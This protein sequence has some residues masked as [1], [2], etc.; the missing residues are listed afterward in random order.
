MYKTEESLLMLSHEFK[1]PIA[2]IKG[3][4]ENLETYYKQGNIDKLDVI[5]SLEAIKR[6]IARISHISTNLIDTMRPNKIMFDTTSFDLSER[7]KGICKASEEILR[8]KNVTI[9]YKSEPKSILFSASPEVTDK[10][11]LNLISNAVKYNN[12]EE[13]K[14]AVS[15]RSENSMLTMKVKDNGIGISEKDKK[16]IFDKFYRGDNSFTRMAEGSGLGL[17]LVK[18]M[19]DSL[20]G[21]IDIKS[22]KNGTTFIFTFPIVSDMGMAEYAPTSVNLERI[23]VALSDLL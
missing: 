3:N 6:N 9:T 18:K 1:T 13:I 20:N 5:Q 7:Y 17:Y 12:S 19:V 14:I 16:R 2:S 23:T 4:V 8:Y 21:E 11:L 15:L 10:I 22:S